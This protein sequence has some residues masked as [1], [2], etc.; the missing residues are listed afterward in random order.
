MAGR[1]RPLLS[2]KRHLGYSGAPIRARQG[3]GFVEI[4]ASQGVAPAELSRM[5]TFEICFAD[6]RGGAI[7]ALAVFQKHLGG[8]GA[9]IRGEFRARQGRGFVEISASSDSRTSEP[10]VLPITCR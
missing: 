7:S 2:L 5:L 4:S 6:S 10:A 3:R 8:P 9:P 1:F